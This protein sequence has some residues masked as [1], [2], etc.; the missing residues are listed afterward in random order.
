[1]PS[2]AVKA[3]LEKLEELRG[4]LQKTNTELKAAAKPVSE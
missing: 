2:M 3:R 4:N 1:M